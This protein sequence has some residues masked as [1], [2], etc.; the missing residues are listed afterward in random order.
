MALAA[1]CRM[2]GG[3]GEWEVGRPVRKSQIILEPLRAQPS[4][5]TLPNPLQTVPSPSCM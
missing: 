3:E 1:V 2:Y 4:P 5:F